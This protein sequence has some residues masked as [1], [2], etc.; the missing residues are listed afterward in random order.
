M[1]HSALSGLTIELFNLRCFRAPG[2][3][4]LEFHVRPPFKKE[5]GDR[6]LMI[7]LRPPYEFVYVFAVYLENTT[8]LHVGAQ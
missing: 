2:T 6:A 3:N 4:D 8:N 7:E 1:A 5:K